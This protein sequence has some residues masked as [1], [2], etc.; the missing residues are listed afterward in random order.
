MV[1]IN[2]KKTARIRLKKGEVKLFVFRYNVDIQTAVF[3]FSIKNDKSQSDAD[4]LI[5]DEQFDKSE[6]ENKIVKC[7]VDTSPLTA[8][9]IYFGEMKT[10]WTDQNGNNIV[11][12]TEDIVIEILEA[13]T[14]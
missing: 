4:I 12:K 14:S 10:V 6:I 1:T 11:D 13:V 9:E 2:G 5:T 7:L 3:T 8:G